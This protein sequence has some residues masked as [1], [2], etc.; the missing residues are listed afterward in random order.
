VWCT[1]ACRARAWRVGKSVE[2]AEASAAV[3]ERAALAALFWG[4]H[5]DA[6]GVRGAVLGLTAEQQARVVQALTLREF[7]HLSDLELVDRMTALATKTAFTAAVSKQTAGDLAKTVATV[8]DVG[9]VEG[10][11]STWT[12]GGRLDRQRERVRPGAFAD[13]VAAVNAGLVN[14]PLV[15]GEERVHDFGNPRSVI[16][17]VVRAVEDRTGLWV[18]A[19]WAADEDAQRLRVKAQSGGLSFSI[20]GSVLQWVP[21]PGGGREL[22]KVDLMH[23]A[24]TGSP[25]N[26]SARIQV[27][28]GP[29]SSLVYTD[30]EFA[31]QEYRRRNP[32]VARRRVEDAAILEA[33]WPPWILGDAELRAMTLQGMHRSALTKAAAERP[34]DP[35]A[36]A[37]QRR[38]EQANAYSHAMAAWQDGHRRHRRCGYGGCDE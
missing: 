2:S 35:V 20:G 13:S 7:D 17:R 28:K 32:D 10:Y 22:V 38:Y 18:R 3:A 8:A 29:T 5:R 9:F 12:D 11:A 21:L 36:E 33:G 15:A 34:R 31:E 25:A 24:V 14:M 23:I 19:E 27:A 16:G 26:S 6:D 1:P 37:Q 30:S 4:R